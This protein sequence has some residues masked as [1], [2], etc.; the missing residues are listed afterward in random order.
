LQIFLTLAVFGAFAY[1]TTSYFYALRLSNWELGPA[2]HLSDQM[3]LAFEFLISPALN[4]RF[5]ALLAENIR[6]RTFT[7]G[8]LADLVEATYKSGPL[9]GEALMF[10]VRVAIPSILDPSKSEILDYQQIENLAHPKLG[11]PIID[12]ANSILTDGVTDFGVPGSL[13]YL[14]GM[15]VLIRAFL[16]VMQKAPA[17]STYLFA[18]LVLIH[19]ALKPEL[20][21]ADYFVTLRNLA[22]ISAGLIVVEFWFLPQSKTPHL[23]AQENPARDAKRKVDPHPL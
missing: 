22:F 8:Y 4:D 2:S 6:E 3:S 10:Y 5:S 13:I 17:P 15:F 11:L 14:V 23:Q 9:Y 1:L 12:Q 16:W 20:T 19:L 18:V 7:I 21:L